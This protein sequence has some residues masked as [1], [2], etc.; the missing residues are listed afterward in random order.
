MTLFDKLEFKQRDDGITGSHAYM[1]FDNGFVASIITGPEA[2]GNVGAPY[3]LAVLYC[4]KL[5]YDNPVA[6]GDVAGYQT[7]EEIDALLEQ[8]KGFD[9]LL[10]F[11]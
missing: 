10:P 2:Y 5:H 11:Y 9:P 8:V 7:R 3:E 1:E 6:N 4:G